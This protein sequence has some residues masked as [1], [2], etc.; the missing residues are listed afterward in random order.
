MHSTACYIVPKLNTCETSKIDVIHHEVV[1]Q[2]LR[3]PYSTHLASKCYCS[4]FS[5]CN[6]SDKEGE[7]RVSEIKCNT[8]KLFIC[9]CKLFSELIH[10]Y[11]K[12]LA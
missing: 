8:G 11:P 4:D 2:Y 7:K 9:V 3:L 10:G 6:Y 12:N 5:K 1:G